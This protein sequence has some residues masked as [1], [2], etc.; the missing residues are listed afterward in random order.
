MSSKYISPS[1]ASESWHYECSTATTKAIFTAVIEHVDN[2]N[3]VLTRWF[4]HSSTWVTIVA[5]K[6]EAD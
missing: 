5:E 6:K 2:E 1:A 3:N 4:M